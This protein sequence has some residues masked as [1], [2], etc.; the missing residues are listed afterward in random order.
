[1]LDSRYVQHSASVLFQVFT[2]D[3]DG[4]RVSIAIIRVCD[5]ASVSVCPHDKTKTAEA[6]ITKFNTILLSITILCP[7]INIR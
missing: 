7:P 5:S 6:K 2:T 4:S 1:M 3:V